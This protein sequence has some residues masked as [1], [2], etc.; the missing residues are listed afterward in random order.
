MEKICSSS[1]KEGLLDLINEYYYS[2]NYIIREDASVFN[3]KTEKVL[4]LVK[5]EKGR[6]I[7]YC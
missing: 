2:S 3:T 1:T 6:F 5:K 7:Y 4:G